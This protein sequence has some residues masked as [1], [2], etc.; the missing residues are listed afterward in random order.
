MEKLK[1]GTIVRGFGIK[2]EVKI[3][4]LTDVPEDRFKVKRKLITFIN[5]QELLL[6]VS[7]LRFH[8]DHALVTFFGYP[9]LTTVEPLVGAN[10]WVKV[11]DIDTSMHEGFYGFQLI[12]LSAFDLEDNL[13]GEVTEIMP[14]NAN[15]VLRI[16]TGGKDILVPYLPVFVK[17]VDLANKKIKVLLMEGMR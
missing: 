17:E 8:Q 15:D 6:T 12:G 3:K 11:A 1:I 13:L 7:S 10:L 5:G 4:I 2:G 9:D 14:T 16:K